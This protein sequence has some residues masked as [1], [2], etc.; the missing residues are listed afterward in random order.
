MAKESTSGP[1]S[2]MNKLEESANK[3]VSGIDDDL[4]EEFVV[5]PELEEIAK[6]FLNQFMVND[7]AS[8]SNKVNLILFFKSVP[9]EIKRRDLKHYGFFNFRLFQESLIGYQN[10][11]DVNAFE[12][13]DEKNRIRV[14]LVKQ[15]LIDQKK[16][17]STIKEALN[18]LEESVDT[19]AKK[20]G[21]D[22]YDDSKNRPEDR[23]IYAKQ[24]FT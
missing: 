17:L 5:D 9:I 4:D 11:E 24:P 1:G 16:N 8:A 23:N 15:Q 14:S 12:Y 3:S 2:K 20:M 19:S 13:H 21:K 7:E 6:D 18:M 22:M 10:K